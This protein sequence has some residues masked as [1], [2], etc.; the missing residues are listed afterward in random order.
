MIDTNQERLMFRV[1]D[2]YYNEQLSQEV[3]A[4]K[5]HISRSTIS[6]IITKAKKDGYVTIHINYPM[7]SSMDL[8]KEFEKKFKLQEAVIAEVE[9]EV[10]LDNIVPAIAAECL[11]RIISDNKKI[12]MSW[13]T[14]IRRTVDYMSVF[15]SSLKVT[16]K[17][18][19]IIPLLG[20]PKMD[21]DYS[22]QLNYSNALAKKLGSI[23][24]TTSYFL[25]SPMIVENK[26]VKGILES[27]KQIGDIIEMGKAADIAIVGIGSVDEESSPLFSG[28]ITSA[29]QKKLFNMGIAGEIAGRYYNA[30]GD[31]VKTEFD[32]RLIG[33]KASEILAIPLRIGI[34]YGHRKVKAIRAAIKGNLV[35]V[36]ITDSI[37]AKEILKEG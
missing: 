20:S 9:N 21:L 31:M 34:A 27:E 25:S 23:L 4:K 10:L 37:T 12:A 5:F 3:I 29:E 22:N 26:T 19:S 30:S 17:N 32:D 24:K 15:V 28:L 36:I 2:M 33:V 8:E 6:R 18:V 11:L 14:T 1:L 35:N 13:G 16:P 7:N